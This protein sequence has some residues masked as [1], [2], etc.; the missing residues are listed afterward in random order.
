MHATDPRLARF[1]AIKEDAR[2]TYAAMLS[3]MD[4]GVGRVLD[5]L[6]DCGLEEN[7]L[8]VFFSDNGGPTMPGTTINASRND[9][10]RGSK[11]TT[12]EG[13]IR[14]PFAARWPGR[15][16]A[17]DVYDHPVIQLDLLP[18]LLAAAGVEAKPDWQLDGVNLLP[19]WTGRDEARRTRRSTGGWATRW[20]SAGA[21]GSSSATTPPPNGSASRPRGRR[22]RGPARPRITPRPGTPAKLYNLAADVGE[23]H[24][25]SATAT[26]EVP[27]VSEAAWQSGTHSSARPLW[28][29]GE[30]E[31]TRT[32]RAKATR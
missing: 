22:P 21:T 18:T 3:A 6:R 10:L 31:R 12:L 20:R 7:T 17:G 2:R 27:R 9:P 11:R 29:P 32:P 28:G 4:E 24:D 19:Y 30:P 14:V 8:V 5:T 25:L 26:R 16:P 1:A 23:A 13:G 15:L